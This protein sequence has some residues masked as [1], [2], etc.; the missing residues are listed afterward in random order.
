MAPRTLAYAAAA[1]R[2]QLLRSKINQVD[3][4]LDQATEVAV[5]DKLADWPILK[6]IAFAPNRTG[7]E[8]TTV[9]AHCCFWQRKLTLHTN[10]Y[11]HSQFADRSP[12]S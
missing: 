4:R 5:T 12:T 7:T 8:R 1:A 9:D 11:S 2:R 6:M 10:L 3:A